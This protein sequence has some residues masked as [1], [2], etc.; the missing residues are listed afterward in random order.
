MHYRN[1]FSIK[2]EIVIIKFLKSDL[3]RSSRD[4]NGVKLSFAQTIAMPGQ[5]R[6]ISFSEITANRDIDKNLFSPLGKN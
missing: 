3:N 2:K 5:T 6:K 1:T 4:V